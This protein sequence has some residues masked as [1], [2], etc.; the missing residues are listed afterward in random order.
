MMFLQKCSLHGRTAN[1]LCALPPCCQ[2][3]CDYC[4]LEHAQHAGHS[5]AICLGTHSL[6]FF[7][8]LT[9]Y[10]HYKV[11][12]WIDV[13]RKGGFFSLFTLEGGD[14][15]LSEGGSVSEELG[16]IGIRVLEEY[17]TLAQNN[18]QFVLNNMN[19]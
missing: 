13:I 10:T 5:T 11:F 4:F 18:R 12:D 7:T 8:T 16:V 3:L 1:K 6:N 17:Q 9:G 14:N 19:S 15:R 2:I